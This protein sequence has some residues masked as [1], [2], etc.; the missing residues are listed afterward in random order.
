MANKVSIKVT[1]K[2]AISPHLLLNYPSRVHRINWRLMKKSILL[3]FLVLVNTNLF[4]QEKLNFK[5]Y[6]LGSNISSYKSD[7][8][9]EGITTFI[10]INYD[11]YIYT[12]IDSDIKSLFGIPLSTVRLYTDNTGIVKAIGLVNQRNSESKNNTTESLKKFYSDM[13]T[14]VEGLSQFYG[15]PVNN[16]TNNEVWY[17]WTTANCTVNLKSTHK[18][19]DVLLFV[20]I[21]LSKNKKLIDDF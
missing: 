13:T 21:S 19:N 15:E 3:L 6:F 2:Q 4:S 7:F 12:G 20:H 9:Y 16:S 14:I 17:I 5:K 18:D 11:V 1:F 10:G 8:T